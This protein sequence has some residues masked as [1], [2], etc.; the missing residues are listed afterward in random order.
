MTS[1]AAEDEQA[2]PALYIDLHLFLIEPFFALPLDLPFGVPFGVPT[3]FPLP[4]PL[5]LNILSCFSNA[6]NALP[7]SEMLS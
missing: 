7:L 1:N 4:F 5:A 3:S 6:A 2:S